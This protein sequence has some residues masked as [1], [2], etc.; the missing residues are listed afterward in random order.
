MVLGID[1]GYGFMKTRDCIFGASVAG[2]DY[3]PGLM[4][5]VVEYKGK[6]YAV[7]NVPDGMASDKT[8]NQ[9]Y[10]I[11]TLAAIAEQLKLQSITKTSVTIAAGLP[12]TRFGSEKE[13]FRKYLLQNKEVKFSYEGIPYSITID[14][15]KLYPQGYA[16]LV[17]Y[18]SQIEG[19]C[20]LVE[21]GTGTTEIIYIDSEKMCDM[22]SAHTAQYGMSNCIAQVNEEINRLF[23]SE[24]KSSQIID[25]ILGKTV[26]TSPKALEV[27]KSA[28]SK[29]ADDTLKMLHQK[30]VNYMLTQ[31]Y[32]GGGGA[33]ALEKFSK[34]LNLDDT[35][36]TFISDI[37]ANARGYEYLA[38]ASAAQ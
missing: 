4:E 30:N 11:L 25:I 12:L 7:G 20:Y 29:F 2:F 3:Q 9:D 35:C 8:I 24:L 32:I 15:V 33:L 23:S 14:D 27:C 10:Y 38:K 31:T 37:H 5:R 21:I 22:K 1:H 16:A 28:I 6:Y 36:I 19:G 13:S 34:N 26:K 17:P 18:F